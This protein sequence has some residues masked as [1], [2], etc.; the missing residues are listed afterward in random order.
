M[1]FESEV[2]RYAICPNC[3]YKNTVVVEGSPEFQQKTAGL[4]YPCIQCGAPL[5][6]NKDR[7]AFDAHPGSSSETKAKLAPEKRTLK[8]SDL[9][10]LAYRHVMNVADDDP[11]GTVVDEIISTLEANGLIDPGSIES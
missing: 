11:I 3:R 7:E 2:E 4:I 9:R 5:S 1:T 6:P 8:R 10:E